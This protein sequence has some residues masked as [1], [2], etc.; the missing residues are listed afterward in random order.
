MD[1]FHQRVGNK[2]YAIQYA[3]SPATYH[4]GLQG[5]LHECRERPKKLPLNFVTKCFHELVYQFDTFE[6]C[7]TTHI[8]NNGV[9]KKLTLSETRKAFTSQHNFDTSSQLVIHNMEIHIAAEITLFLSLIEKFNSCNFTLPTL[10]FEV[11]HNAGNFNISAKK[12]G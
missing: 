5:N 9:D 11:L 6:C 7:T 12:L 3:S 1:A 8:R 10:L 4:V 2:H